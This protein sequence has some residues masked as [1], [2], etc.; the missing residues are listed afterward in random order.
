MSKSEKL[1]I[2]E[3]DVQLFKQLTRCYLTV[4]LIMELLPIFQAAVMPKTKASAY[5]RLRR[6]Y[7]EGYINRDV[8]LAKGKRV[9]EYYYFLTKKGANFFDELEHIKPGKGILRHLE[10]GSQDHAF[11]LSDVI[12][13]IEKAIF[14]A[15]GRAA[16]LGFI[17]ENYFEI[18]L[19]PKGKNERI[20]SIKPDGTWFLQTNK[21]NHLLFLEVDLSTEPVSAVNPYRKTFRRKIEIYSEFRK[22]FKQ[23]NFINLFGKFPGYRVITVCKSPQRVISL[24]DTA[25]NMGKSD[26]FWFTDVDQ[27]KRKN[28]LFD[29]IWRLPNGRVLP[30]L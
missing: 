4:D 10:A 16:L 1:Q 21:G 28:V 12:V 3:F 30:L 19:P 29:P 8:K 13:Q 20:K 25:R 9:N 15:T 27:I 7:D 24:L 14:A 6:L 17:R 18:A 5:H 2:S 22:H 23:H 11:M 26:M